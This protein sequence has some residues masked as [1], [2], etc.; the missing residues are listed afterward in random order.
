MGKLQAPAARREVHSGSCDHWLSQGMVGYVVCLNF[1]F[2]IS[3]GPDPKKIVELWYSLKVDSVQNVSRV[4]L[5]SLTQ[6]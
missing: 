5:R 4:L 3:G 1:G 6:H 2:P